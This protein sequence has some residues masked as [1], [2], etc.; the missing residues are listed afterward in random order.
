MTHEFVRSNSTTPPAGL[1]VV[2]L[3]GSAM[4]GD[5]WKSLRGFV[6]ER[7]DVSVLDM[8]RIRQVADLEAGSV[9]SLDQLCEAVVAEI[10]RI[11]PMVHLV[12][13]DFGAVLA[14]KIAS[15][16]PGL[17]GSLTLIEPTAYN[18]VLPDC[19]EAWK[20]PRELYETVANMR[21]CLAEGDAWNAMQHFTDLVNGPGTWERTS[22]A[23]RTELA[24]YAGETLADL[25]AISRDRMSPVDLAGVVCPTLLVSGSKSRWMNQHVALELRLAI[26]FLREEIVPDAGHFPHLSDPHIVDPLVYEFLV[27]A[28]TQWQD[29]GITQRQAA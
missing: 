25:V 24:L 20:T 12:G 11:G 28:N 2:L 5:S 6:G 27:R 22:H 14:L 7:L 17:V 19:E 1:P 10:A 13:H 8:Y 18:A 23:H 9:P 3:H 4:K 26:P 16:F 15:A 29:T 21:A